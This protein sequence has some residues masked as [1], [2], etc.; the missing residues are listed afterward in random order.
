MSVRELSNFSRKVNFPSKTNPKVYFTSHHKQLISLSIGRR[1]LLTSLC[2]CVC[3]RVCL[4]VTG[5]EEVSTACNAVV[6]CA[7]TH[8]SVRYSP[9]H[10][11]SPISRDGLKKEPPSTCWD[12]R[13]H[14]NQMAL[15]LLLCSSL[16]SFLT[17]CL[18]WRVYLNINCGW[19][20]ST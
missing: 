7:I 10:S 19:F 5:V 4:W 9:V 14:I 17:W 20:G 6:W 11:H 13:L 16:F 12:E 3:M 2:V 18:G 1:N 8:S 15:A